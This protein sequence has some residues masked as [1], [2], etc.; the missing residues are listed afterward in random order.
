[1]ARSVLPHLENPPTHPLYCL[2]W[3]F[4]VLFCRY[5]S[6]SCP[7]VPL[8]R[9]QPA[10]GLVASPS[11]YTTSEDMPPAHP[12]TPGP[13]ANHSLVCPGQGETMAHRYSWPIGP[14][15]PVIQNSESYVRVLHLNSH[16]HPH[17]WIWS[18]VTT[19]IL[20]NRLGTRSKA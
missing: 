3:F 11:W 16:L 14:I 13:C 12:C 6:R 15:T 17:E 9:K 8:P 18:F 19:S 20:L 7:S 5:S 1:M 4:T 10:A 2:R